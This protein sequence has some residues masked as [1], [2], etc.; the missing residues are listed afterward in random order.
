MNKKLIDA[1][2]LSF[3]YACERSS[4]LED[5]TFSTEAGQLIFLTGSCG[6][7]KS[8][9]LNIL[10][11]SIPEV[12]EG[13]L[14]GQLFLDGNEYPEIYLRSQLIGSVFQNPRSQFFTNNSTS[15]L[16]FEMEN[17][18]LSYSQMEKRLQE[19]SQ[20]FGLSAYLDHDI[21]SLSS[22]ERQYL[23]LVSV[24]MMEPQVLIFDEPSANLDYGN[25]MRLKKELQTL[26]SL[27]KTI[28]VADHRPFYLTG[29]VDKVWL[30]ENRSISEVPGSVF[31][32]RKADRERRFD[33]FT[34]DYPDREIVSRPDP[35][36]SL[37]DVT[38]QSILKHITL[39]FHQSQVTTILGVNG[40]GKTTLA[41]LMCQ[42]IKA[43]EG[44]IE[45][46]SQPLYL[47]Q[48][49]DFQL[50]GATCLKELEISC[51]NHKRN[52]EALKAVGLEA[53]ANKH[54]HLL[55]GGQKQALQL[56]IALVSDRPIIIMDEP[57]SGM[58]KANME[59]VM[60]YLKELKSEKTIILISHDYEF[61][62]QVTD[63]II[64]IHN[65]SLEKDFYLTSD[66]VENLD[67]IFK[68]MEEHYDKTT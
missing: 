27:G 1:N 31:F 21:L 36:L 8:T 64:F 54:P 13:D 16:V 49:A 39:S 55:S 10:N 46:S 38:Y 40:A 30:M 68:Q 62:R 22:G 56:A 3:T 4:S 51:S 48:D 59:N 28:I 37:K 61:I 32:E 11:G 24:L 20:R 47:M 25:T 66:Q 44:Q 9:L 17:F 15:E 52:L 67:N 35:S 19:L 7:G 57:T 63:R 26:K 65:H 12:I 58:D 60:A 2:K 45:S 34:R 14:S 42:L 33:L 18:G 41:R 53:Y 6:S 50:F 29:L 5:L 43:D 23:A